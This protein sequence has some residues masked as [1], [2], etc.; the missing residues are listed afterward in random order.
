MSGSVGVR[1]A[2]HP[3]PCRWQSDTE[4]STPGRS[5]WDDPYV[6]RLN[7]VRSV[8]HALICEPVIIRRN[9]GHSQSRARSGHCQVGAYS[10]RQ[11]REKGC[12]FRRNA[13]FARQIQG[14]NRLGKKIHA[15]FV[16]LYHRW[17]W[18]SFSGSMGTL[19]LIVANGMSATVGYLPFRLLALGREHGSIRPRKEEALTLRVAPPDHVRRLAVWVT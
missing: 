13:S 5:P 18:T 10:I 7:S 3:S 15:C 9:P 1:L 11:C 14:C 6:R 4:R 17:D 19:D 16:S 8:D 12:V 2:P